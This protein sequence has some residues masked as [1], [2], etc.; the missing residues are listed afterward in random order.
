MG[1]S[2]SPKRN[3]LQTQQ[4]TDDTPVMPDLKDRVR[5]RLREAK[6]DQGLSERDLADLLRWSHSKVAKK[7]TGRTEITLDELEALCGAVSI[8]PTEAVRDRGLEFVAEMTPTELRR[9]ELIR[10][11][12]KN[13]LEAVDVLLNV[14]RAE[15]ERRGVTPKRPLY[16]KP[17]SKM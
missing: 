3:L 5:E 13:V 7:L 15:L 10:R 17:R 14:K 8:S 2:V 4:F 9:L 16:G 6:H 1:T 11:L 12:P